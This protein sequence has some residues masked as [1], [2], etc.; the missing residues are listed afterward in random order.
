MAIGR[1]NVFVLTHIIVII[2]NTKSIEDIIVGDEILCYDTV[3]KKTV[4]SLVMSLNRPV[5]NK[6]AL[7]IFSIK[8]NHSTKR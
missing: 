8:N 3:T 7:L 1:N 2:G 6:T 4:L 5:T